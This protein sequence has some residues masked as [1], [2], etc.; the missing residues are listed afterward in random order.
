MEIRDLAVIAEIETDFSCKFGIPRQSGLVP[1][2]KGRIVFTPE[3]RHPDAVRGLEEFSHLWLLW[4]FSK[5][6]Q[7][8]WTATVAPP[9]LGGRVRKGVFAT[10]SPYRPNPI[11]LSVV[12]LEKIEWTEDKGAVLHV[13]GVD[14]L[15]GT[16]IYDIK[17]YLPYAD[18]IPEATGGWA[19][20]TKD[21]AL[22]VS[23]PKEWLSMIPTE[24][25]KLV[26][27]VLRQDPRP[28]TV[29]AEA[30]EYRMMIAG[31]DIWFHVEGDTAVVHRVI[32]QPAGK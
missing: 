7:T 8:N 32:E 20:A 28:G 29:E 27:D 5:S 18:A 23:I 22:R 1:E 15:N 2:A 11:G 24:K 9:R 4:G 17:P 10:R 30:K 13:A 19:D 21:Y 6:N 12:A 31:L 25:R 16:P 26:E 3:Y 14:L